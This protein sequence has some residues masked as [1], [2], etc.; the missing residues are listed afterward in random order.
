MAKISASLVKA[1][2]DQT[3]AGMMDCKKALKET[4]GDI[5]AA[6]DFLRKKGI[7][8]AG[9][10]A[11]RIAAEGLVAVA[12]GDGA[13]TMIEVNCE[14]DFVARNDAFQAFVDQL[15]GL[16][17]DNN[18]TDVDALNALETDGKT[19][20]DLTK[21]QIANI[22]ENIQVRRITRLSSDYVGHYIHAGSQIGVLVQ[23]SLDGADADTA[24][25]F[26]RNVAMHVAA[27]K[28][29]YTRTEEIDEDKLAKERKILTEQALESG[30]PANIVDKMVEGRLRK[31][32]AEITLLEQ[33]YVRDPDLTVGKYQK[34]TGGVSIDTFVRYQ[35]GE[36]IEKAESNLAEEVAQLSKG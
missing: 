30:K 26:A 27:S 34:K 11:G 2:R 1:L 10:K 22:G 19:V 24:A 31:W 5:E 28:P 23:L 4:D 21:E 13:A 16:A 18:V 15:A 17:H 8:K 36:G 14:T 3:G 35:V 29:S 9:K 33:P 7:A 6:A 25:E 20:A 12:E 32:K